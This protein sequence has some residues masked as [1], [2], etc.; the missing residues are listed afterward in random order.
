M[1]YNDTDFS[2]EVICTGPSAGSSA[3]ASTTTATM[4]STSSMA[5]TTTTST[6]STISS[7]TSP[8]GASSTTT[9]T[10]SSATATAIATPSG[11]SK[12]AQIALSTI[13]PLA[14]LLLVA[15]LGLRTWAKYRRGGYR[16]SPDG[17]N[18]DASSGNPHDSYASASPWG[19]EGSTAYE[20]PVGQAEYAAVADETHRGELPTGQ[21]REPGELAGRGAA[22][23]MA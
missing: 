9:A 18:L 10:S 14:F 13:L 5:L 6:P 17:D 4:P 19:K 15:A 11:L 20:S 12:P 21:V 8:T 2:L 3:V 1:A 22:E 23:L 7:A 16:R